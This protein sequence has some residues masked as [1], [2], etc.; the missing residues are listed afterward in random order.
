[1]T[2]S[3]EKIWRSRL[4]YGAVAAAILLLVLYMMQ[5]DPI[6]VDTHK[7][8]AGPL[9]VTV[10]EEGKTRIREVYTVS[11]PV[12][13]R[14]LRS[15]REVGDEIVKNKTVVATIE[16]TAPS[17]LDKR[18]RKEAEAAAYAARAAAALAI[19]QMEKTR[20]ELDFAEADYERAKTLAPKGTVSER[21]LQEAKLA[22]KTKEAA[23]SSALANVEVKRQE[24][25]RAA[26]GL[27]EPTNEIE[28]DAG[29]CCIQIK[30]PES[31]KVLKI[32]VESEQ[33]VTSGTSLLE[34][35]N[36]DDLEVVIEL[37]SSDTVK[38]KEGAMAYIERWGGDNDLRARVRRI[39]P[40]GFKKTSALGIEEQRVNVLLDF[41]GEKNQWQRLGHDYRVFARI[42]TWQSD[43]VLKLPIAALFRN[44]NNWSVFVL[45]E[46]KAELRTVKIGARNDQFAQIVEG[47]TEGEQV[48][49]HPSDRIKDGT[50]LVERS[51]LQ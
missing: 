30:S 2:K 50:S 18:S 31:G 26:A 12:A 21:Q 43:R 23:H 13:G 9:E 15:P 36:P 51:S 34:I 40:A 10:N 39:E 47:V 28:S 48:I 1:M 14:I 8:T 42:V 6:A 3:N 45:S 33:V 37:L 16:P 19:A 25:A 32:M 35:G 44:N 29:A 24:L 41:V 22:L 27:I 38:V 5:P 11:A 20:A 49:V 17:F 4:S 46:G 7:I